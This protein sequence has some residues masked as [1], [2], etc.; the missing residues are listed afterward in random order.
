MI[1][2][3]HA[4][5]AVLT[6]LGLVTLLASLANCKPMGVSLRHGPREYVSSDYQQVLKKWTRTEHLISFDRL[7][8]LL[9][10]TATYQSHDFRWAYVVRYAYDY[11]L[12][13]AQRRSEF[14]RELREADRYHEFFVALYSPKW[15][16]S[17]LTDERAAWVVRMV[18]DLGNQTVPTSITPV[19]K[20]GALEQVYYPYATDWRRV[21]RIRFP[22]K[23]KD[24][25]PVISPGTRWFGLRFAGPQ[26]AE[27][28]RWHV[29]H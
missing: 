14:E 4:A 20:P 19:R 11:Q 5:K 26:G 23:K 12:T 22:T 16:W 13:V 24:G 10:V 6:G 21:Y 18:D 25:T 3:L 8:D 7:D 28:L 9:T 2:R 15:D 1:A 29:I 27:E 17:D